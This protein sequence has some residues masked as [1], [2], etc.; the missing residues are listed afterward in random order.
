MKVKKT[1]AALGLGI[2][3][4]LNTTAYAEVSEGKYDLEKLKEVYINESFEVKM[5]EL[6]TELLQVQYKDQIKEYRD[7]KDTVNDAEDHMNGMKA[8]REQSLK[9]YERAQDSASRQAATKNAD[10]LLM[11]YIRARSSYRMRVKQD[12]QMTQSLEPIIFQIAQAEIKK[13]QSIAKSEYELE[14][15]Y[16]N[17]VR[18]H[19]ELELI[20]KDVDNIKKKIN[21][22]MTKENLGLL[23]ESAREE[24]EK[25]L[26]DFEK[27]KKQLENSLELALENMKTKLNFD[28]GAQ[29]KIE[30]EIPNESVPKSYN[31]QD[32]ISKFKKNNLD[33]AAMENNVF[34]KESIFNKVTL[35]YERIEEWNENQITLKQY[36]EEQNQIKI[37]EIEFKKSEIQLF[38]L[39]RKLELYAKNTY[40]EYQ[41]ARDTLVANYLFNNNLYDNKLNIIEA[42]YKHGFISEFEYEVQK[43]QL[44][45][46]LRGLEQD[47]INYVN[48]KNK[49]ELML[50]GIMVTAMN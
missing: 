20:E 1:L 39:E 18:L 6:D 11:E 7:S 34:I 8:L 24:S 2:T 9:D 14:L 5:I 4:L 31:L 21:I 30:L 17:L 10:R 45:R 13:E 43:Q 47:M 46:E 36:E 29:L 25:Q 38:N 42:N 12:V 41:T 27:Q 33:L 35:A 3:M 26:R 28:L 23:V 37:S 19:R 32:S 44:N 50:N 48:A 16:Y 15:D 49:M 40:Y 22:D